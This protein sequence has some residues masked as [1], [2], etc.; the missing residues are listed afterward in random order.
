VTVTKQ[1]LKDAAEEK[2]PIPP[3]SPRPRNAH[4]GLWTGV[5]PRPD[6]SWCGECRTLRKGLALD[7]NQLQAQKRKEFWM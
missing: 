7:R 2:G 3:W 4:E 1:G 5:Q 6:I